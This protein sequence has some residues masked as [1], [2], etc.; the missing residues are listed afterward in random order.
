MT[1]SVMT[2]RDVANYLHLSE[3][4]VY[5]MARTGRIPVVHM[6]RIWRFTKESIDAWIEHSTEKVKAS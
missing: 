4:T 5:Q 2:V 6:G 3:A 1:S